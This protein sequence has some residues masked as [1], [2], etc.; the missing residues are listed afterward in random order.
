MKKILLLAALAL[1][2]LAVSAQSVGGG[3]SS[4]G[5]SFF[6]TEKADHGVTFG[7]R[8]GLNVAG[9][10]TKAEK[11]EI[12]T[13]TGKNGIG[14]NA[15]LN[16]DIPIVRSM[17]IQTGLYWTVKTAKMETSE[18]RNEYNTSKFNPSFIE[19]PLLASY[20]YNLSNKIQLQVNLGPYFAYGVAGKDDGDDNLFKDTKDTNYRYPKYL[21]PFDAGIKV[22]TGITINR[23]FVGIS[24]EKGFSNLA[25]KE[26][27]S[28]SRDGSFAYEF[29]IQSI[30]THNF[31]VN[32]GYDF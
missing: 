31:S 10:S 16:V 3:R 13:C 9:L 21:K 25:Y 15:G 6:S 8:G 7:I 14:Y 5:N 18:G 24:Y 30:K 26:A 22:G 12:V 20:R 29:N 1:G 32:V 4:G 27:G 2:A 28:S 17:Y 11:G 23:F 19:I